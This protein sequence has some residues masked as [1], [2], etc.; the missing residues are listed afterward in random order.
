MITIT[1]V[2]VTET[3]L[4]KMVRTGNMV[5][6]LFDLD[7]L[8]AFKSWAV[9]NKSK[10]MFKFRPSAL[11]RTVGRIV[12]RAKNEQARNIIIS[13]DASRLRRRET[14][15]GTNLSTALCVAF[16][17]A[18]IPAD[19][20]L[21]SW[22]IELTKNKDIKNQI[23]IEEQTGPRDAVLSVLLRQLF[24]NQNIPIKGGLSK[25]ENL[26]MIR[27][28]FKAALAGFHH[29]AITKDKIPTKGAV[30]E[31]TDDV[32]SPTTEP[33]VV[34]EDDAV[35][36]VS[37]EDTEPGQ[38]DNDVVDAPAGMEIELVDVT[39]DV[40]SVEEETVDEVVTEEADEESV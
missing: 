9:Q 15:M 19:V 5:L 23:N 37:T 31:K 33:A 14:W 1:P 18:G 24:N 25:P 4:D 13:G 2:T 29:H 12:L 11:D 6:G 10:W 30:V 35:V 40:V 27:K 38:H 22:L 7:D 3:K 28:G 20:R 16:R 17:D 32:E 26:E 39:D 36:N 8:E 21:R 34:E